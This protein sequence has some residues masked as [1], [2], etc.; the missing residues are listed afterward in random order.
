MNP[1]EWMQEMF[2]AAARIEFRRGLPWDDRRTNKTKHSPQRRAEI[3]KQ[4]VKN[5]AAKQSRRKNRS[6]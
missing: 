3:D 1:D 5:K 6:H 4:R 2:R